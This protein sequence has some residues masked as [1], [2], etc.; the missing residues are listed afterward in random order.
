[1]QPVELFSNSNNNNNNKILLLLICKNNK[2]SK[3]VSFMKAR[4]NDKTHP[5]GFTKHSHCMQ[6]PHMLHL[7]LPVVWKLGSQGM[8]GTWK[9]RGLQGLL[10]AGVPAL[11]CAGPATTHAI[12]IHYMA[13]FL[14]CGCISTWN[15]LKKH[16]SHQ[17]VIRCYQH[18]A[19]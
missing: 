15:K 4:L 11:A 10:P 3:S 13:V 12:S 2:F 18:G 17:S 7:L 8:L 14:W 1:M 6:Q 5:S 9:Q 19:H 16:K